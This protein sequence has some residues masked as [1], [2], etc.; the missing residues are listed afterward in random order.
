MGCEVVERDILHARENVWGRPE[1]RVYDYDTHPLDTGLNGSS[2][3]P[4]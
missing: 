4:L 3:V 1:E 2:Q